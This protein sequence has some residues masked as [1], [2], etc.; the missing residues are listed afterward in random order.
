MGFCLPDEALR[1]ALA[2]ESG[3]AEGPALAWNWPRSALGSGAEP[4]SAGCKEQN[5]TCFSSVNTSLFFQ[6]K[7]S[8]MKI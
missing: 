4:P 8:L 1:R 3:R 6:W 7:Q 5:F 2:P